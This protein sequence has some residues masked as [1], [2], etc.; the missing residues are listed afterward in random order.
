MQLPHRSQRLDDVPRT[1]EF[2]RRSSNTSP[3]PPTH[4]MVMARRRD[5]EGNKRAYHIPEPET[6]L[7]L[8]P[9]I[10]DPSEGVLANLQSHVFGISNP[11]SVR[12]PYPLPPV[13]VGKGIQ[14]HLSQDTESSVDFRLERQR[15]SDVQQVVARP[16]DI[17]AQ[18][19]VKCGD[20][21]K[22]PKGTGK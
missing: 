15:K 8:C 18:Q 21:Q 14:I 12:V 16:S 1:S 2:Q 7:D 10:L 9:G 11:R 5:R 4:T 3:G 17:P 6:S 22:R 13:D 20:F 19:H